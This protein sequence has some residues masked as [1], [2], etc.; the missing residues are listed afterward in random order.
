MASEK[1]IVIASTNQNKVKEIKKYYPSLNF[2][3][4][5]DLSITDEVV[6]DGKT[7]KENAIKKASYIAKKYQVVTIADDSGLCCLAL[8]KEP[9]V[10]SAR[11][12]SDHNDNLNNLKLVKNMKD[13]KNKKAYYEASICLALP[14]GRVYTKSKKCYGYIILEPRGNNG[15]GY[16]PYFYLPKFKKTMAELTI[17]EKNQISHRAKALKSLKHILKRITRKWN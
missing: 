1:I 12:A 13:K 4:L 5:K 11:Y 7:F 16:D 14:N 17:D 2:K 10:Y 8:N 15:F 6:E 3:S 9:G